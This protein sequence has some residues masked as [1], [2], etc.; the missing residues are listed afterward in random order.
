MEHPP[1]VTMPES[2][3]AADKTNAEKMVADK[4]FRNLLKFLR[5]TM[6]VACS[7]QQ[8]LTSK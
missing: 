7:H 5:L 8:L 6:K 2:T 1:V 4:T 3:P